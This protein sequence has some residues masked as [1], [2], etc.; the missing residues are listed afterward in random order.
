MSALS[1]ANMLSR[2]KRNV[3]TTTMDTE[4]QD[5]LLE[6]MTY[7]V[8]LDIFP[9]QEKY[10]E[11]SIVEGTWRICTPTN[12]ANLKQLTIYT[13]DSERPLEILGSTEFDKLFPM[14]SNDDEDKPI[15]C[16]VRI[17]EEEIWFNCPT[18]ATYTIRIYFYQIPDDVTDTTVSQMVELAKLALIEWASGQGFRQMGQY[19]RAKEHDDE[20]NKNF[21][22]LEKRYALSREEDAR[23]ISQKE[24]NVK[25]RGY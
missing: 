13:A 5:A 3:P 11:A 25:Y 12:F 7:L 1:L 8:S 4:L 15:Y 19:D 24:M 6:K 2:V 22:A 23:M 18:D 10:Q 21:A 9:F 20:G 16:S 17:A 14:P